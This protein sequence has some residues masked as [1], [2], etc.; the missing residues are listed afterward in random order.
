M[1]TVDGVGTFAPHRGEIDTVS[2]IAN[3][4]RKYKMLVS[5]HQPNMVGE[6]LVLPSIVMMATEKT[7]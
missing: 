3:N 6:V 4:P 1:I 5:I 2:F 7:T